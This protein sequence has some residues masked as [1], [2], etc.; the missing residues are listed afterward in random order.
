MSSPFDC[1]MVNRG[2]KTLHLRMKEH[3]KNALMVAHALEA[4]PRVTK[5]IHPGMF[6][7]INA[8][9]EI[10][11]ILFKKSE[12]NRESSIN[13]CTLQLNTSHTC[14]LLV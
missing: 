11:L 12:R 9:I 6:V 8:D 1:Y 3:M 2:V 14:L 13:N 5:V 7:I 10:N 4:N